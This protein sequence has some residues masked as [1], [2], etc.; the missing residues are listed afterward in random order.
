MEISK[1]ECFELVLKTICIAL[2]ICIIPFALKRELSSDKHPVSRNSQN[3]NHSIKTS[4]N[5]QTYIYNFEKSNHMYYQRPIANHTWDKELIQFEK[6]IFSENISYSFDYLYLPDDITTN[7]PELLSKDKFPNSYNFLF[8]IVNIV[9]NKLPD[10]GGI[11][12]HFPTQLKDST[13]I[14]ETVI[15]KSQLRA[16]QEHYTASRIIIGILKKQWNILSRQVLF[17]RIIFLF[18]VFWNRLNVLLES[19]KIPAG[20][21]TEWQDNMEN[22]LKFIIVSKYANLISGLQYLAVY[23]LVHEKL[24]AEEFDHYTEFKEIRNKLYID[25]NVYPKLDQVLVSLYGIFDVLPELLEGSFHERLGRCL[26][27]L[28]TELCRLKEYILNY[29]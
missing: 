28:E 14:Q 6:L 26:E 29:K 8:L 11:M 15:S 24:I 5:H 2:F 3:Q 7:F 13:S 9:L 25:G 1:T 23:C 20:L 16:L 27:L 22:R 12:P 17:N 19:Y 21:F 10:L 18:D 4:L